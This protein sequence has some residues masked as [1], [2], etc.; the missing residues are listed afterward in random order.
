MGII[1]GR[2]NGLILLEKKNQSMLL[3]QNVIL[4]YSSDLR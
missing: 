3:P 4:N 1:K 2:F